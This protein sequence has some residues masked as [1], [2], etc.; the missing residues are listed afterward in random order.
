MS[1]AR[2]TWLLLAACAG[3]ALM[4]AQTAHAQLSGGS[5]NN[6]GSTCAGANNGDGFCGS[7]TQLLVNTGSQIQSRYAWNVNAD[8]AAFSTRDTSGSATHHVNFSATAPGSYRVTIN[9]SRSGMVQRNDD[10]LNCE[11]QAHISAITGTSNIALTSGGLGIAGGLDVNNGGGDNQQTLSGSN[12]GFI[13]RSSNGVTQSHA[14]TFTWSGNVRS[15]SCEAAIRMGQ[16]NGSTTDCGACEYP[17][18][19]SRTQGNDG[20]FVTVNFQ[21]FCGNGIVDGLGE[22]CDLG[23]ANGTFTVCCNTNCTRKTAGT[24]CSTA[25]GPCDAVETCTGSSPN[26]PADGFLP[27]TSICRPSAGVCDL[28]ETCTGTGPGCPFDFKAPPTTECRGAAG[29]C[30]AVEFCNGGNTC[31]TDTKLGSTTTCRGSGGVCDVAEVCNGSSNTCPTD[32]FASTSTVCRAA[33]GVCDQAENCTGTGPACP[34]NTFKPSTTVCRAAS[35]VC[36]LAENCTGTGAA[37]PADS[38]QTAGVECRASAGVCDVAEQCN[39]TDKTCPNDSTAGAF[40]V[41][42]PAVGVCD[43]TENCDGVNVACPAD[44]KKGTSTVCRGSAGV[45]DVAEVCN[46]SSNTCPTN[47]FAATTVQCR[48]SAGVCDVAEFC[49]GSGAACP[50]NTFQPSST[51]CRGA[52]D[53]CD[54]AENCTGSGAACPADAVENAGVVCRPS[55]GVCDVV[56]ECD[57]VAKPCPADSVAGAFVTCRPAAGVCDQTDNC[58]GTNVNCPADAKKGTTTVCRGNAGVCDTVERCDG[59]NDACPSDAF[60]STSTE[61]RAQAGACD[62]AEH[63]TGSGA[64]CPANGFAPSTQECRGDAGQCDVAES[65]TGSGPACPADGFEPNGTTCDDGNACVVG[66]ACQSGACTGGVGEVCAACETCV[67]GTGCEE[68]PRNDCFLSTEPFRSKI[69]IKDATPDAIDKVIWKWIRGE[70]VTN[71]DFGDPTT[72]DDYAFCVYDANGLVMQ[73]HVPAAGTC[74]TKPCWKA[75]N[76]KGYK[77][78]NSA[79]TPEGIQK[80]LVKAGGAGLS[81]AI[82]KG[83]GDNLLMPTTM[84]L[85]LNVQAELRS[86]NGMCWSTIHTTTGTSRNDSTQFK[87]KDGN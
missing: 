65:C 26:C 74:G 56:E 20:H 17:G 79:T 80:L 3:V 21:S 11:G 77:Y 32:T 13:D 28:Q 31:P 42:R 27:T 54:V 43:Q 69:L 68:V 15:N 19:P 63:C 49:T 36:D 2:K 83:K 9:T 35:G 38:I 16:Q 59:S 12:S 55:A 29:V 76:G 67:P 64:A 86:S 84:P 4:G 41:C 14:L 66:E 10:L 60:L 8:T 24:A 37:C 48:G 53:V 81:K 22:Q 18:I 85:I 58:D 34:A 70:A 6:T 51:V 7:S 46:G 72:T 52:S 78:V 62:V 30:D 5:S 33:P 1:K 87:S 23:S 39:G 50:A 44:G 25:A 71:A 82:L 73:A 47:N 75:L 40:V 57:G 61:C 45:C